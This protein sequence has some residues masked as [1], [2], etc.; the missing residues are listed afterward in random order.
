MVIFLLGS[1]F[2]RLLVYS[3]SVLWLNSGKGVCEMLICK[4]V[5]LVFRV[6]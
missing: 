3:I 2:Y 4:L 6:E 5:F 1:Y